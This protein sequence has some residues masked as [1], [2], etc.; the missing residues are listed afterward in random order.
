MIAA[1]M[2]AVVVVCTLTVDLGP[3]ARKY[4]VE[5]ATKKLK[6]PVAIGVLRIHLASGRLEVDDLRI[7]GLA[8]TDRPFFTARK[9]MVGLDWSTLV[10]REITI[11]SVDMADWAMVVEKWE[12]RQNFPKIESDD[13]EPDKPSRT[14]TILKWLRA[15]RGEFT[16]DDHEKP[17]S[18]IARNLEITITNAPHYDGEARFTGGTVAIQEFVPMWANM[19]ASFSIAKS[20]IHLERIDL[21]TDGAVSV[22]KGD[23][24]LK[25]FPEMLFDVKSRVHFPRMREIFFADETWRITG[26][27]DFTGTFH[28]FKGGHDLSGGFRSDLTGVYD[29]RFPGTYGT[30]RWTPATF[31]VWDAGSQFYGGSAQFTY[32]IRPLGSPTRPT[33]RFDWNYTDVDLAAFTDFEEFAGQRFAGRWSGRS[34]LEWPAG[35]FAE[36]RGEGHFQITAPP[37]ASIMP[38]SLAAANAADAA[39]ARHEWGP[40]APVPLATHLPVAAEITYRF[41]P[42]R[43]EVAP[44]RFATEQSHVTFQ[45]WTTWGERSQIAFHATSGDLQ[46][47]DLVLVGIMRDFGSHARPVAFGGRGEFD[48][49]LTGPLKRPRVE[50]EFSGDDLRGFDTLWGAADG[51]VV[52]ENEYLTV[53]DASVRLAGS[54]I[55]ASGV[56][57]LGY[58]RDDGGEEINARFR[59]VRHDLDSLRH[60]FQIDDYPVSGLLS[61]EFHLTGEYERPVGF[62]GMTIEDGVAYGEPFQKGTASLRFDRPGVRLDGIAIDKNG[63][64]VTGAA[65]VGWDSTYSFNA[66]GQRIPI[67]KLAAFT[68]PNSPTLTG[69]GEFSATGN[70]TFDQPR[71]DLTYRASDVSIG[72]E[73]I[74]EV[75]GKLARRGKEL[76]GDVTAVSP[77]LTVTG[78]GRIALTPQADAELTFRFHDS[79]LDP[80]VRLFVPQMSEYT[81]AVAS[82][83]IRVVG[84]LTDLDHLLVDAAVDAVSL[85]LIDY[86]LTN[87]AP[88]RIALDQHV[89]RI[90]DLQ[91]VGEG[92]KLR[93]AGTVGLH[94]QQ[95]ALRATGDANLSILQGF[96]RDVR[97]SGRAELAAA[98]NGPLR[99]PVFSGSAKIADGRI[100]HFSLPNSLDAING[101]IAFDPRGIRLDGVTATMGEGRVRFGGRV[102]FAGYVPGEIDVTARGQDMHLRVPDGV[103][104]VV[105]ADLSVRGHVKTPTLGGTVTVKNAVWTKPFDTPGGIFDVAARRQSPAGPP[106]AGATPPGPAFALRYDVQV[107]VPS[108]LR[109]S[110]NLIQQ[111]VAAADLQLRGSADRPV[112]SGHADVERGELIFE[113]RRYKITRGSIGFY[114][115]TRIEP[116]FDAEA[117]T[118]VRVPGQTYRVTVRASGPT[119]RMQLS[120]ES[121][122]PLPS[123]DVLA[124]LFSDIRHQPGSTAGLR[125]AEIAALANPNQRQTD[126]LA[127]RA[128]QALANPISQEVGRVVQQTFGVDT[129]QL[130]P[131]LIDPYSQGARVNPSARL[132]IGKRI[133]D[134][135]Y[136]TFS[137]SLN[138]PVYDQIIL[139]EYDATDRVS[140]VVSRNEDQSYALEFRFRHT[141]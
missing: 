100:R 110:N 1:A 85:K 51:H 90:D 102:G 43:V 25:R 126:I 16:Y 48:G 86:T 27:A 36:H 33:H 122:P 9:I 89:V 54:E 41:D 93:V 139:L 29:Y 88:V 62:G 134:R 98:V 111:M 64:V 53:K 101:V 99:D 5:L 116:F 39:H 113:G 108:T 121:D 130:S 40:F 91:L 15:T 106:I 8:P 56:F 14:R 44:S 136:L 109:V 10:R 65:Y 24:D 37:G 74:G 7:D 26:D 137:R 119:D 67:E 55:R 127:T 115:P 77:R 124:L 49:V 82:G 135:A 132:T 141:F 31:D 38:A 60:A 103:R 133:S 140:V 95:I 107:L 72:R 28:L 20:I 78:A 87:A 66:T 50:G 120:F 129:F 30:L 76:S 92:T 123:A 52:V 42:D 19:R 45:G 3:A 131:S 112:L 18:T 21:E 61:G 84:E 104:S 46:E 4:A 34:L 75:S 23:V 73:Q 125:N 47:S 71:F 17:W 114:N 69:T 59:V 105:D 68:F 81:T 32:S 96:F 6:R 11:S 80:Y 70:A 35:R 117:E 79:S 2:L 83:N 22:C 57:A 138:T 97:G 13:N 94:D 12:D 128:T 118:N 63:G 58:P